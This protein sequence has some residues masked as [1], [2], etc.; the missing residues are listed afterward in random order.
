[1]RNSVY[2]NCVAVKTLAHQT[3]ATDTTTNGAAVDLHANLDASRS[4]MLVVLTGT[5]TDGDY[6]ITLEESDS[7]GSGYA[8]VAAADLQGTSPVVVADTD[9]DTVFELG[10]VGKKRYLRAVVVSTNTT[11]GGVLSAVI[12]RGFVRRPPVSHS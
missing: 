6:S 5:L 11:S 3:I 2:T 9:D 4:A 12:V 10:Y 8:A 1:M 7:S